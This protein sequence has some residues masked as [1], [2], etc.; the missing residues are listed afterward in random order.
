ML[1][2][3]TLWVS[4]LIQYPGFDVRTSRDYIVIGIILTG[5]LLSLVVDMSVAV[6]LVKTAYWFLTA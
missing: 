6:I 3:I 5:L 1:T 4:C 2:A